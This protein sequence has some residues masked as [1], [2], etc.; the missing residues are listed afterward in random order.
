MAR[1]R[2]VVC[3]ERTPRLGVLFGRGLRASIRLIARAAREREHRWRKVA[4]VLRG[5]AHDLG[6]RR[7]QS[8]APAVGGHS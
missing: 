7:Q 2:L 6:A 5:S 4:A 8:R 1:N 3:G